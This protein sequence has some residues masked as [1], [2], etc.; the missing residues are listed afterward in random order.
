MEQ[1]LKILHIE[2]NEADAGLVNHALKNGEL[3]FVTKI[4]ETKED[5]ELALS[6]FKPDVVLSDHSLPQ[7]NSM[8]A[9]Q[10]FKS[11]GLIIPFILITGSVSEDFA[12]KSIKEGAD[13][14]ILKN[15]L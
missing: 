12:V 14:Y 1:L 9:L 8:E 4:V 13:D 2:D 3:N 10:I 11:L 15:S 7:F 6:E 5:Y